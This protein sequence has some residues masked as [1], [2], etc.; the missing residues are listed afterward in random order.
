MAEP[1]LYSQEGMEHSIRRFVQWLNEDNPNSLCAMLAP[2]FIECSFEKKDVVVRFP[3]RE[4]MRNP[5]GVMHGGA[6]AA[7]MDTG[8]G[9]QTF[10]W[11]G[12]RVTPTINMLSNFQRPVP[13]GAMLYVCSRVTCVGRTMIYASAD[14]WVDDR[15][16]RLLVTATGVY[17][18]PSSK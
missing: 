4:W 18:I 10:Y 3:V 13:L 8:M 5:G 9:A 11:A 16:D 15:P 6:V 17:H 12:E 1:A 14:A 2:E 7:A